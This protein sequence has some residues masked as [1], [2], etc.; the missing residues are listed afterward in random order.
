MAVVN[1][2]SAQANAILTGKMLAAHKDQ[3]R[4]LELVFNHTQV[5]AGDATSEQK[6]VKIPAGIFRFHRTLSN[7]F[8]SAFGAARVLDI[9]WLAYV[10]KNGTAVAASANGLNDN[11]DV[12][13]A[14][15][16][17]IGLAIA[18]GY[19]DFE[20]RDGVWITSTVA[21]GTIPAGATLDGVVHLTCS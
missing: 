2:N 21:G 7:I 18:V 10:D 17:I 16:A 14:G 13:A 4:V 19:K 12:S 15:T 8:F 9:G 6:L 3:A 1:E 5:V 11:I 20:S